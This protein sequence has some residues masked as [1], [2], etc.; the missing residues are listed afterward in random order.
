MFIKYNFQKKNIYNAVVS[1]GGEICKEIGLE[2][3]YEKNER[4]SFNLES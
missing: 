1:I 4:L 3:V 2:K